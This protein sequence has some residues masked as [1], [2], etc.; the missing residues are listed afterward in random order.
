MAYA[1]KLGTAKKLPIPPGDCCCGEGGSGLPWEGYYYSSYGIAV[2]HGF[3]GTEQEW[4]EQER[5]YAA[6]AKAE[7]DRAADNVLHPPMIGESGHWLVW[8]EEGYVDTG[9][10]AQGPRGPVGP[11]GEAGSA[12]ATGAAG[13]TGATGAT[14]PQGPKGDTGPT[15]PQGPQGVQGPQGPQGVAVGVET[16]G[17]F[18]FNVDEDGHLILTYTG[19]DPPDFSIDEDTGHLIWTFGEDD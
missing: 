18:Y 5:Y 17:L 10:A 4:L 14:G 11:Q 7:A 13:P 12:G 3:Q 2:K 19:D 6:I 16:Q 15:G 1:D 8:T 9:V